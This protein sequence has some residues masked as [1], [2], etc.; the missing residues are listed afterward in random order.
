MGQLQN[1][2]GK[3]NQKTIFLCTQLNCLQVKCVLHPH[4][5][6]HRSHTPPV[7]QGTLKTVGSARGQSIPQVWSPCF[8][9]SSS[10]E[11]IPEC[12]I[13]SLSQSHRRHAYD[14]PTQGLLAKPLP[15][16]TGKNISFRLLFVNGLVA[17]SPAYR[18]PPGETMGF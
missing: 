7:L 18:R 10:S 1:I 8:K 13:H 14:E 9:F 17:S 12:K 4:S 2:Y 15:I 6:W 16:L 5:N 3:Q 11:P